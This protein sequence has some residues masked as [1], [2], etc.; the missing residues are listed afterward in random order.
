MSLGPEEDVSPTSSRRV[1]VR[2]AVIDTG[3]GGL[4]LLHE[5]VLAAP[6][7]RFIYFAD[8]EVL[9]ASELHPSRLGDRVEELGRLLI[10]ARVE[11]VVP[12]GAVFWPHLKRL[13][14]VGLDVIDPIDAIAATLRDVGPT[15][16]TAVVPD[17]FFGSTSAQHLTE[18]LGPLSL[19]SSAGVAPVVDRHPLRDELTMDIVRRVASR[20]SDDDPD[21]LLLLDSHSALVGDL[22]RRVV[23]NAVVMDFRRATADLLIPYCE[24]TLSAGAQPEIELW[25]TGAFAEHIESAANTLLQ[26]P[27][28][29]ATTIEIAAVDASPSPQDL[30]LMAYAAFDGDGDEL[31]HYVAPGARMHDGQDLLEWAGACRRKMGSVKTQIDEIFVS[32]DRIGVA[33]TRRLDVADGS[34][35]HPFAHLLTVT[36]EG[37]AELTIE[38]DGC[39]DAL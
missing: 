20:L 26:I 34:A 32:G 9:P 11:V 16:T 24:G 39:I 33:G 14:D 4:P 8:E 12:A 13:T 21:R 7:A 29:R 36:S 25:V 28:L 27:G 31:S 19:T 5:C 17:S 35:E 15:N 22:F 18:R 38:A 1:D 37:I 10:A 2:I 30:A 23:P 6:A 3:I